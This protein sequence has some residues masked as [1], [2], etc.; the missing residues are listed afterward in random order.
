MTT[1]NIK[2][3]QHKVVSADLFYRPAYFVV[4]MR[5]FMYIKTEESNM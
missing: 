1:N 2:S 4:S 5:P 3:M